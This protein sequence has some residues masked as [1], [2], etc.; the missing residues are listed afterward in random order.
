M[1]SQMLLDIHHDRGNKTFISCYQL[2]HNGLDKPF[3]V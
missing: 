3:K 1:G 2:L